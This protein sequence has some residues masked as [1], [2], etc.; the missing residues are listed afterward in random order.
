MEI[1]ELLKI[2]ARLPDLS[3]GAGKLSLEYKGLNYG[4]RSEIGV[5]IKS[6]KE[7]KTLEIFR[8]MRIE[9]NYIIL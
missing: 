4:E 5:E 3:S 9:I 6:E 1:L 8:G 2:K 7:A